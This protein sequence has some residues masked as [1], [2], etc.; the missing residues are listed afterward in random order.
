MKVLKRW[1]F[2]VLA[3]CLAVSLF[4]VSASASNGNGDSQKKKENAARTF[5]NV[6][7][8]GAKGD[9]TINDRAAVQAAI[10]AAEEKGGTVYLPGG[11]YLLR[12]SGTELLLIKRPIHI[13]GDGFLS[14]LV[15][16]SNVPNTTD[17]IRI[18]PE[19]SI[20]WQFGIDS[21]NI[22]PQEGSK[23]AR[24]ALNIDISTY[25]QFLAKLLVQN[26]YFWQL[27]GNSVK[28]T[29][30][31]GDPSLF[32]S[33]FENNV[34]YGGLSLLNAGDSINILGN[35][36]TGDNIGVELS[37]VVGAAKVVIA[38][39]NI[40]SAGGAIRVTEGNQVKILYNQIEQN[41]PH[42]SAHQAAISLDGEINPVVFS[43]IVGNNVNGWGYAGHVDHA[44]KIGNAAYT[45]ISGN[46]LATG[47]LGVI[48]VES[49][50]TLTE[51]GYDNSFL[52]NTG[53][54][55]RANAIDDSG[56]ITL[57]VEKSAALTNGWVD[58]DPSAFG[59]ASFSRDMNGKVSLDGLIKDGSLTAGTAILTLPEG[60]RPAKAKKFTVSTI[61]NG[62]AIIGEVQVLATGQVL[63]MRGG[64]DYLSLNGISFLAE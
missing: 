15:V 12:G 26:C 36:I 42:T 64:N 37:Q 63:F 10:T 40:T 4:A 52:S 32:T 25:P 47:T 60:F 16:A 30:P 34:F 45:K 3:V 57:G 53:I 7:D 31:K 35:T 49:E 2:T 54:V 14:R 17:V 11:N 50:A 56:I 1:S 48:K 20:G 28:L 43:Q 46:T 27:G 41:V 21:I 22:I 13:L 18:S 19:L 51:I 6:K 59:K 61:E 58:Y 8:Y 24:H 9:G 5:F 33:S 62:V 23:P 44:I 55:P 29:N 38:F 39:N